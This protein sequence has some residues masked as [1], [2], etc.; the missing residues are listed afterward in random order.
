MHRLAP[1]ALLLAAALPAA[2]QPAPTTTPEPA[3]RLV[4]FGE[5][6]EVRGEFQRPGGDVTES[7]LG[8]ALPSLIRVRANFEPELLRSADDL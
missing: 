8:E 6:D 5:A 1:L 4:E 7:R 3:A 2:A